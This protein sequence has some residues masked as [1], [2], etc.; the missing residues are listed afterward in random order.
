MPSFTGPIV[1]RALLGSVLILPPGHA[2]SIRTRRSLSVRER[3]IL[4][5]VAATVAAIVV[6]V[7]IS[8]ATAGP[9][10]GRGCIY[11]TIPSATGA[12]QISEC[13]AHARDT[14]GTALAPGAYTPQAS[15]VMA[16]ACRKAGLHVSR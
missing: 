13:G 15:A 2:Q 5:G 10:S 3:W 11:A 14:C 16:E 12:Q 7:I 4:R 6:A 1:S 8:L 9:T